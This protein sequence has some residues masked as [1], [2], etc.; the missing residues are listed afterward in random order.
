M[1]RRAL[2]RFRSTKVMF[3]FLA[4]NLVPFLTVRKSLDVMSRIVPNHIATTR[5]PELLEDLGLT[6]RA[7]ALA[8]DL[9]GGERQRATI[10]R[11]L[12]HDPAML[13]VAE[14]RANL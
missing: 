12:V 9:S 1:T 14:P 5:V 7:H 13:L 4:N 3:V 6:D 2:T 8:T 10:A 11:A